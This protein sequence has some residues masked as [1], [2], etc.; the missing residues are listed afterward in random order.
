MRYLALSPE[1]IAESNQPKTI[2]HTPIIQEYLM[3]N[4]VLILMALTA[5]NAFANLPQKLGRSSITT[6]NINTEWFANVGE[7]K[8]GHVEVNSTLKTVKLLVFTG[9]VCPPGMACAQSVST[10]IDVT[11]PIVSIETD[12]C[13]SVFTKAL[14]DDRP[15]DGLLKMIEVCDNTQNTCPSLVAWPAVETRYTVGGYNRREGGAFEYVSTFV[16]EQFN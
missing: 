3:K 12:S 8:G 7:F 2:L 15:V 4:F 14:K 11:L 5:I 10:T 16:G 9:A 6:A 1:T 13:G